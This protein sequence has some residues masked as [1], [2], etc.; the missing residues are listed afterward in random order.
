[1]RLGVIERRS[2]I[3]ARLVAYGLFERV[4][5]VHLRI[6]QIVLRTL[7]R[8]PKRSIRLRHLVE[9]SS[10]GLAPRLEP[11]EEEYLRNLVE[12]ARGLPPE[13]RAAFENWVVGAGR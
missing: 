8:V 11:A 2:F 13:I 1:M 9:L 12:T 6:K 7:G 10:V 4:S 3:Y 5:T